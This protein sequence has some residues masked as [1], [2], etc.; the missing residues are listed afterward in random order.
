[1]ADGH[2]QTRRRPAVGRSRA[3]QRQLRREQIIEATVRSINTVGFAETTLATVA[4][5]AGVSQAAVV[6]H[7]KSKDALLT[8]TLRALTED[9]VA[10]WTKALAAAGDGPLDRVCAL[11]A[12]DFSPKI[13]NR[14][15]IAVWFAFWGAA[16]T[17]PT[18]MKICGD[19]D[20]RRAAAMREAV[21]DLLG[22]EDAGLAADTATAIDGL[23]DGMWQ[24]LLLGHPDFKREDALRIVFA[25][26]QRLFPDQAA[27][28]DEHRR[29]AGKGG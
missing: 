1:M 3:V 14:K 10:V 17:R 11:A 8:E 6:F 22:D 21:A 9:Y 18:Y 16:K 23:T 4:A 24:H 7:F 26:L 13:C 2:V 12:A 15:L 25:H 19:S 28:I 27:A 5:E 20:E 29:R